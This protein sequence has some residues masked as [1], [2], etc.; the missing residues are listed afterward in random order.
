MMR[1]PDEVA[2]GIARVEG[3]GGLALDGVAGG[4]EARAP[5]L[6]LA[7]VDGQGHEVPARRA[8]GAA[9]AAAIGGELD[10]EEGAAVEAEPHRARPA[11]GV[12]PAAL[13]G[14]T[15]DAGVKRLGAA[16]IGDEDREVVEL[17]AR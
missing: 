13:D 8:L 16:E 3:E 1:E 9:R 15:E 4:G 2:V 5:A 11:G 6:A 7:G 17:H 14:E 10:G 12:V